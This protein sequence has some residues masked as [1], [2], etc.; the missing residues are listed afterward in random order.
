[1]DKFNFWKKYFIVISYI[2]IGIGIYV[3]FLKSTPLY[4][5]FNYLVDPAFWPEGIRNES[6]ITYK[7]FVYSLMGACMIV[8]G[9]FLFYIIKNAYDSHKKWVWQSLFITTILWFIIDEFYSALYEVYYN[10]LFNAVLFIIII[11]PI[12][13][14]KKYF[15]EKFNK[16]MKTTDNYQEK[17]INE[18]VNDKLKKEN[19]EDI[20]KL[21]RFSP[22][23]FPGI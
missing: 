15:T 4:R 11:I 1:M 14:T 2:I 5:P 8:W 16:E 18:D 10:V 20:N 9:I 6:T 7:H 3:A 23:P 17:V 19:D 22:L 12:I 21:L 13:K